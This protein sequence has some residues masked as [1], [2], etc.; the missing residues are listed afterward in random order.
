MKGGGGERPRRVTPSGLAKAERLQKHPKGQHQVEQRGT[1]QTGADDV[2]Q[3]QA[4]PVCVLSSSHM[5]TRRFSPRMKAFPPPKLLE[6]SQSPV[7]FEWKWQCFS[8]RAIPV[9]H[10]GGIYF[11]QIDFF[12]KIL[13]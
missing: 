13:F 7:A 3:P 12:F 5:H 1:L 10:F 11:M 4:V 6:R 9:V 2:R 8:L